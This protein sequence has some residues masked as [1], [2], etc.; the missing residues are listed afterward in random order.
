[1]SVSL[2]A[3]SVHPENEC[4]QEMVEYLNEYV[5]NSDEEDNIEIND[6]TFEDEPID[7]RWQA[8]KKLKQKN[9]PR[10]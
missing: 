4:N 8:L 6:E 2:P 1:M 5:V 3:R 10:G 7:P 9:D